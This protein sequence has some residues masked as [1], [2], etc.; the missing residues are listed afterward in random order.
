MSIR[1]IVEHTSNLKLKT[2]YKVA[3]I[4][5]FI[6]AFALIFI[7]LWQ[8][9]VN[10]SFEMKIADEKTRMMSLIEDERMLV[11]EIA[12]VRTEGEKNII[13]ASMMTDIELLARES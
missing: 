1:T 3:I 10:R 11:T 4:S 6:I 13:L 12:A 9:G 8:I 7:P 2:S 5:V